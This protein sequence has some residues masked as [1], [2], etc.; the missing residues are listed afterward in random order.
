MTAVPEDPRHRHDR[1]YSQLDHHH[2]RR[3]YT[4]SEIDD[5]IENHTHPSRATGEWSYSTNSTIADPG[6]GN[7]RFSADSTVMAIAEI[8]GNSIDFTNVFSVLVP[9]DQ[10]RTQEAADSDESNEE[11]TED[12]EDDEDEDDDGDDEMGK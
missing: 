8:D 4:E 10:I 7:V 12:D 3:Y 5:L 11:S 1:R 2:D 9:G 6:N